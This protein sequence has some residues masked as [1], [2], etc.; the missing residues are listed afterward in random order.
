MRSFVCKT[1]AFGS[2]LMTLSGT[3][4]AA[5]T[6]SYSSSDQTG[7]TAPT[8]SY[9]LDNFNGIDR[10]AQTSYWLPGGQSGC[11]VGSDLSSCNSA[12]GTTAGAVPTGIT[13]NF[14][15]VSNAPTG[16]SGVGFFDLDL[17]QIHTD[18]VS[19]YWGS[20][21]TWNF[22]QL[23]DSNGN[24]LITVDGAALGAGTIDGF[25]GSLGAR[26]FTFSWTPGTDVAALQFGDYFGPAFEV[27]NVT[28]TGV[29]EPGSL[30]L[31]AMGAGMIGAATLRR[32][33]LAA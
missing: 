14:L 26:E 3:A 21:D 24:A 22:V 9:V 4:G 11:A 10:V 28:T 25:F 20:V 33:K 1:I 19:F 13:N 12:I 7:Y 30:G 16:Q 15:A 31:L 6:Y 23:L 5:I 17:S 2:L 27:A 32:R 29:P 18:N 8:G